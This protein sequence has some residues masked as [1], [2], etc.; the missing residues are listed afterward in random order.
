M[1][2]LPGTDGELSC[3]FSHEAREWVELPVGTAPV[4]LTDTA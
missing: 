3:L 4:F 1:I 2:F